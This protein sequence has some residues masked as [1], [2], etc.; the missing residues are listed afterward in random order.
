MGRQRE[1]SESLTEA[2]IAALIAAILAGSVVIPASMTLVGA[3]VVLLESLPS[4]PDG[5]VIDAVAEMVVG[6]RE[7]LFGGSEGNVASLEALTNNSG[8]QALYAIA[9]V[10]RIARAVEGGDDL[11]DALSREKHNHDLH[12]NAIETRNRGAKLNVAAAERFGNVLNWNHTG[13]ART[14]RH[15]HVAADGKNYNIFEPPASTDYM[16]PGMEPNC[17]CVPAAPVQGAGVLR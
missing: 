7:A 6:D 10:R 11:G 5:S 12:V 3:V 14:H 4:P 2:Q 15:P 13:T 9:A 16:L 8:Y 17:D 1:S